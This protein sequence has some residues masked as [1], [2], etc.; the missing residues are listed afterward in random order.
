MKDFIIYPLI[1][2]IYLSFRSALHFNLPFPD[3]SL[4]IIFYAASQKPSIKSVAISFILGYLNDVFSGGIIGITSFSLVFI[5]ITIHIL[6]KRMSFDTPLTKSLGAGLASILS[7]FINYLFLWFINPDISSFIT[8]VPVA[9]IT[10]AV[11]APVIY[12]LIQIDEIL[13]VKRKNIDNI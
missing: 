11:A 3:L 4:I 7:G 12:L 1:L 5:F 8:I 13:L 6:S 2:I 9:F 10:G